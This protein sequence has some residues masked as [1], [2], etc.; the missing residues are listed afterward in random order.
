[1]EGV[2]ASIGWVGLSLPEQG[3]YDAMC[4]FHFTCVLLYS[5][6]IHHFLHSPLSA[7]YTQTPYT[8]TINTYTHEHNDI[9]IYMIYTVTP[10]KSRN[11]SS[12]RE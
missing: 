6:L 10:A 3:G 12:K 9:H 5:T 7:Y 2:H 1:M 4:Y 8:N 11:P